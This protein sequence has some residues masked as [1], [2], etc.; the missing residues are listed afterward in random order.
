M[1]GIEPPLRVLQ[2]RASPLGHTTLN[3][4][5][6]KAN[7]LVYKISRLYYSLWIFYD[8]LRTLEKLDV[9]IGEEFLK[10]AA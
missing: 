2:T 8:P 4:Y 9:M 7:I 10:F 6:D 5:N 3:R 1:G